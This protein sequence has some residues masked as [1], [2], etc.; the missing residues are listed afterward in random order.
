MS[1]GK[2][3]RKYRKIQNMTQEEMAARL[4]V[5]APAVNKWENENSF[6]D[7]TLLAPIARLLGISMDTLFSFRE[8]LTAEEIRQIIGQADRKLR[9]QEYEEAFHWAKS[10]AAQY[11]NCEQLLL[12]LAI[13]LDANRT[14]RNIP[15]NEEYDAYLCSLYTRALNSGTEAIRTQAADCLIGFYRRKKQYGKAEELLSYYS[16][17]NPE[18]KRRQA[19]LYAETGRVSQAYKAYEELL[20]VGYGQ[21]N[22][23]LQGM[24]SLAGQCG[25]LEKKRWLAAKQI[26]LAKCFEM[27]TYYEACYQLEAALIEQDAGA[28]IAA[29]ERLLSDVENL[30]NFRKSPLY[31]H[32][33]FKEIPAEFWQEL[34]SRLRKEFQEENRCAFLKNDARWQALLQP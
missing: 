9:T 1:L 28:A 18:R 19:E 2:V 15:D 33:E 6:P 16:P 23:V 29:A 13:V 5:T 24:G 4:G 32:M 30:G 8:E 11:P 26:D 25:D 10:V 31:A 14:A 21:A 3:I 27:G 17:Q 34:K 12:N 20:F 22:L 7:I